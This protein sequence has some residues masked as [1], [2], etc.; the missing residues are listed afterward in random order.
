MA[1]RSG[2][3]P[4]APDRCLAQIWHRPCIT[5][6]H[7]PVVAYPR[8]ADPRTKWHAMLTVITPIVESLTRH[9]WKRSCLCGVVRSGTDPLIDSVPV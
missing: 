6:R 3:M 8:F 1:M 9:I 2:F 7:S 4:D 5:A